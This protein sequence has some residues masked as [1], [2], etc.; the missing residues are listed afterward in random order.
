MSESN[1]LLTPRPGEAQRMTTAELRSAFLVERI[2]VDGHVNVIF[3][4]LDR[5]ALG[6]ARPT[7][8]PLTLEN[9]RQTGAD[10]F[11]QRR[12]LGIINVGGAGRVR[13]DDADFRL[14]NLDCLYV[15]MGSKRVTF[16]SDNAKSP[17]KFFLISCPAHGKF[18]T[19]LLRKEECKPIALGSQVTANQRKIFQYIHPHG[20]QSCQLVMGF[21]DLAEGSVWNTMPP[22]THSRRT[23]FYF[24]FDL[25]E[26]VVTHFLGEPTET[27]HVIVHNEQAAL[28]PWWSIHA[29]CG[30]ANYKF[31]W[32][33]AGENQTFD[34]M[35]KVAVRDLR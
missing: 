16:E 3:T 26:N 19:T 23:E 31:I 2:F 29:G 18:P 9:D 12:E 7:E 4:D 15:E 35:D 27:R 1:L 11:L 10:F 30:T 21:T 13:V 6:G 34:D 32:A 5:M 28:S 24:Y 33:M 14:G 22:H 17:A 20:I 8:N 25:G